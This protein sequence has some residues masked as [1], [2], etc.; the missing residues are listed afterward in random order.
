MSGVFS[1]SHL[2]V[3]GQDLEAAAVATVEIDG[4]VNRLGGINHLL[5]VSSGKMDR[6]LERSQQLDSSGSCDQECVFMLTDMVQDTVK[7]ARRLNDYHTGIILNSVYQRTAEVERSQSKMPSVAPVDPG[8]SP[9]EAISSLFSGIFGSG[10]HKKDMD[11]DQKRRR[12]K[13]FS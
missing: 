8:R 4:G 1:F 5:D 7:I 12:E 13:L 6:L 3:V 10:H 2:V 9:V 11:I